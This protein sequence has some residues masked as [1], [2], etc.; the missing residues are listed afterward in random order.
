MKTLCL[1][2]ALLIPSFAIAQFPGATPSPTPP[3]ATT[4]ELKNAPTVTVYQMSLKWPEYEGKVVKLRFD[5][6]FGD[7]AKDLKD[8]ALMQGTIGS[9]HPTNG[10]MASVHLIF[11]AAQEK[12]Y[13]KIVSWGGSTIARGGAHVIYAR[14]DKAPGLSH[15]AT[16]LGREIRSTPRGPEVA[17]TAQ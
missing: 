9:Y 11:P 14:I 15:I 7:A 10:D 5:A 3:A 2:A 12:W 6:R 8:P 17:W 16:A 1:L 4:D 13:S